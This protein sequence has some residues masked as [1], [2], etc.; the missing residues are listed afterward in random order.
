MIRENR[1]DDALELFKLN[2]EEYPNSSNVY[3]SL[4]EA[5]MILGN[6]GMAVQNYK[7]S[8]ELNPENKNAA[9]KLKQLRGK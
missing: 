9:E 6:K 8:L 2:A 1:I 5:W 7:R 3:D 4:G